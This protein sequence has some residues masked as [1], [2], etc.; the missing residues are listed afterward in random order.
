VDFVA[1]VKDS[2]TDLLKVTSS[3]LYCPPGDFYID[4][5]RPV[6]RAVVTHAHA[7]HAR[8]GMGAY[9]C[10]ASGEELLRLRVG[11]EAVVNAL[12]YGQPTRLGEVRLSLHPAG[13]V[14]GSAQVRMEAGGEVAVV[15]GDHN[16]THAHAAAEPFEVVPCDVLIT[17]CT[18]GLPIYQWPDPAEVREEL[19]EWWRHNRRKGRTSVLPCYPLGKS[20]RVLAA[21]AGEDAP[22]ALHGAGRAFLPH[23][24]AAGILFPPLTGFDEA[25]LRALKGDGLVLISFAGSEPAILKKLGPLSFGAAS[26][27]MR[28]RGM[29][30]NRD[31]DR[32]F[33]LS[34]HSDWNGLLHCIR[35]SGARRIGVTHGQTEPFA[36]YLTEQLGLESFVVP[37]RFESGG[38]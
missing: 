4:P 22:V 38:E 37:T 21:L 15:T 5:W 19:L 13:H 28:V 7:D 6:P 27:W 16:A 33:I 29:R 14:L 10:A 9:W 36:R 18:F 11:R 26:G 3:G 8:S 1:D 24:E 25:G 12:P 34:D 20:Q 30:R 17:E 23:Y 32:G 31:F 2:E 35:A